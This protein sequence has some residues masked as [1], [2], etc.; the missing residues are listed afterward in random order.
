[1]HHP[2]SAGESAARKMAHPV[3]FPRRGSSTGGSISALATAAGPS[4]NS[5]ALPAD[6][7]PS[8]LLIQPPPPA[9]CSSPGPQHPPQSLN[10]L[11]SQSQLQPQSLPP[12]GAQIKKKSGFQI[13]S[14]T[15][16]QI[17]ASTNNSIAEDTESYDDLDESHTEDLSSSEIL[18][19]SS[20]ATDMGGPER[21]SSEET[22]NNFHEAET[23]GAVSPNQPLLP[24]HIS[25][26]QLPQNVMVNGSLH[27]HHHGHHHHHGLHHHHQPPAP[28]GILPSAIHPVVCNAPAVTTSSPSAAAATTTTTTAAAAAATT[29]AHPK[30]PSSGAISENATVVGTSLSSLVGAPTVPGVPGAAVTGIASSISAVAGTPVNVINPVPSNVNIAVLGANVPG[31]V[32]TPGGCNSSSSSCPTGIQSGLMNLNTGSALSGTSSQNVN[33]LQQQ[34]PG[35]ALNTNVVMGVVTG[36]ATPVL[37]SGTTSNLGSAS[38]V[39]VNAPAMVGTV[40]S[41]QHLPSTTATTASSRF[42]VVKLDSSSEPF[43]KGRWT[44][45][46]YYDKEAP[47]AASTSGAPSESMPSHRAVESIRQALTETVV[48]SERESTSGSSVSSTLSTLSHYTESV[49]SGEM[50]TGTVIQTFQQQVEYCGTQSIQAPLPSLPQSISQPQLAQGQMHSQDMVHPLMKSTGAPTVPAN[51]GAIQPPSVNL[52]SMQTSIGHPTTSI[53]QQPLPFSQPPGPTPS[54][55]S[56]PQQQMGYP[57]PQQPSA[58]AHLTAAHVVGNIPAEYVQHQQI[59]QT[60]MQSGPTA[61]GAAGQPQQAVPHIPGSLTTL[62]AS[63]NGQ[64]LSVSQQTVSVPTGVSQTSTQGILQQQASISSPPQIAQPIQ[65][66]ILQQI[67]PGSVTGMVPQPT[68]VPPSQ[69]LT[70]AQLPGEQQQQVA[71]GIAIQQPATV[72]LGQVAPNVPANLSTVAQSSLP[73]TAQ[74]VQNGSIVSNVGPSPLMPVSVPVGQTAVAQSTAQYS[75][76]APVSA[77]QLDDARRILQDQSLLALPKVAAGECATSSGVGATVA[78]DAATGIS[79]LAATAVLFPLKNLPLTAHVVDGDEDS[80][81]GASVVAIDNKIEQAMDLVKSHLMY[82]VREEVEVLKEQIKEL[83]ERNSQLEQENNLLKNLAS[84][85][86]L[87]QFQAQLQT[88]SP[89]SS[90]QPPGTASQPVQPATQSSGP[91]A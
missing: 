31:L 52:S 2:E 49:G 60:P 44:C 20:R 55:G 74:P 75:S 65:G 70:Q 16:A 69:A 61:V 82:A 17:S 90:S 14:V 22:L 64:I 66:G 30:L 8:P 86:Q 78:H 89:P 39:P 25:Q 56:V 27:P 33:V 18:D 7:Y 15:P 59:L 91:S 84:P 1:M 13:T 3:V 54:L 46:E 62:P 24:H 28:H 5:S 11:S 38:A 68:K 83:I 88:G 36:S 87:A 45:T 19:V 4:V 42:R 72:A 63:G 43:R 76:V 34:G 77:P 85:E 37:I 32:A 21:S 53:P 50:G 71:Q 26:Q 9:G 23:P 81:S 10:L 57:P 67:M 58:P 80:S 35:T 40:P 41:G 73:Q 47:V 6:D 48:G 79:A 51:V 29:S 12:G